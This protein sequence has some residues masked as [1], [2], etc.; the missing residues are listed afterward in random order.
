[1]LFRSN[2]WELYDL[3][4]DP[5]EQTDIAAKHPEILNR[6]KA[7]LEQWQQSVLRSHRGEDYPG[8]TIAEPKKP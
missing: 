6:M 3:I 1:M 8:K 4:A 7:E 2:T 5:T